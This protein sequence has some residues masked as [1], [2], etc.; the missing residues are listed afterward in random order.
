MVPLTSC[1]NQQFSCGNVAVQQKQSKSSTAVIHMT[2]RPQLNKEKSHFL[3][4]TGDQEFVRASQ[5]NMRSETTTD[6]K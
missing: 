3:M 6:R 4:Y 1:L 5:S 2:K